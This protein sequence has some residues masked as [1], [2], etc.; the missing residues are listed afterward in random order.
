MNVELRN[1]IA[2]GTLSVGLLAAAGTVGVV[3]FTNRSIFKIPEDAFEDTYTDGGACLENTIY[4]L[5][6]GA[7]TITRILDGQ[8][9]I[10]VYPNEKLVNYE[11]P[12][13]NFTYREI[14]AYG[15]WGLDV[16]YADYESGQALAKLGCNVEQY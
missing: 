5:N 8:D 9:I 7:T 4:D 11:A 2:A 1:K 14:G 6:N 16:R 10:T 13:L 12:K 3:T 15:I